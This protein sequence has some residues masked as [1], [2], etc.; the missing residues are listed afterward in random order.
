MLKFSFAAS[1]VLGVALPATASAA[2]I[3]TFDSR[4]SFAAA[5]GPILGL[6]I[7]LPG[8]PPVFANALVSGPI[9]FT[10]RDGL[11][12]GNGAN[13]LSTEF[14]A[15]ALILDFATPI[16]A[17]GLFG[18]VGDV[19]FGY[20]DGTVEVDAIGS[21]ITTFVA[22]MR[23]TY[24]GFTS[25]TAFSRLK[26]SVQSFDGGV[27]SVAFATLQDQVDLSGVPEPASWAL[28]IAGFGAIGVVKR[29]RRSNVARAAMIV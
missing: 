16:F 23:P 9:T 11:L 14:D 29:H 12:A 21:G 13:I 5:V 3:Q 20:F 25:D 22:G 7:S 17:V 1:L 27:S 10:A 26:L 2:I 24:F 15:D 28:M 4:Q 18:G 19:D 8:A 6:P